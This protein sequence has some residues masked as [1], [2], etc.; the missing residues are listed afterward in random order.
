MFTAHEKRPIIG[1]RTIPPDLG[2][3]RSGSRTVFLSP[4]DTKASAA[5][6]MLDAHS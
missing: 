3:V 6:I 2:H 5:T 1:R 4:F